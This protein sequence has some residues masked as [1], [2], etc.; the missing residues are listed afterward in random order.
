MGAKAFCVRPNTFRPDE[1]ETDARAAWSRRTSYIT[2]SSIVYLQSPSAINFRT[3]LFYNLFANIQ[4]LLCMS[5]R[6]RTFHNIVIAP[7]VWW[8]IFIWLL[9]WARGQ[10]T[11]WCGRLLK[12]W[13]NI[14]CTVHKAGN[15]QF[16]NNGCVWSRFAC[17]GMRKLCAILICVSSTRAKLA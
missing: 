14:P 2:R 10:P 16:W 8:V 1:L 12:L 15:W 6:S 9:L 7:I 4:P 17:A 5:T 3:L 13:C 11:N